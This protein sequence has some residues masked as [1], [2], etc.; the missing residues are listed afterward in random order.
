MPASTSAYATRIDP[1]SAARTK[2]STACCASTFPRAAT[3]R[4][5]APNISTGSLKN[6]TMAPVN[7]SASANPSNRSA[8]CCSA[9][10][11][12]PVAFPR[13]PLGALRVITCCLRCEAHAHRSRGTDRRP[14]R[15]V[16]PVGILAVAVRPALEPGRHG[17]RGGNAG[18]SDGGHRRSR[19]CR[20]A[21]HVRRGRCH[22]LF[23]CGREPGAARAAP[24][25]CPFGLRAH[26][27]V[28]QRVDTS[29]CSSTVS[30]LGRPDV[31]TTVD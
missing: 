15:R 8:S 29:V 30:K 18:S 22:R 31:A 3:Y 11:T 24:R 21:R 13:S 10:R 23:Q 9:E 26:W 6:S 1:G 12:W 7:G 14:G 5:T 28:G 2:T 20:V 16:W 17:A 27:T 25:R 4:C 19:S